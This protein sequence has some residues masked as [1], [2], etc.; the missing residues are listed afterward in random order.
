M[1]LV[2]GAELKMIEPT[3]NYLY[4]TVVNVYY[5]N[6]YFACLTKRTNF[7]NDTLFLTILGNG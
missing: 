2:Y 6:H 5:Y 7:E 4:T 3:K 1:L